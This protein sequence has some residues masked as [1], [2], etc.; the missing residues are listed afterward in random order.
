MSMSIS[1]LPVHRNEV[2]RT[3]DLWRKFFL[4][5]EYGEEEEWKNRVH[6]YLFYMNGGMW[7]VCNSMRQAFVEMQII[8]ILALGNENIDR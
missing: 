4:L 2:H 6:T 3:S 1:I 7:Y 5:Q 8:Q